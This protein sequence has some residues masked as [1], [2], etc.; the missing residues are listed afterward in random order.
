[1]THFH[2]AFFAKPR[3]LNWCRAVAVVALMSLF[4]AGKE[5][6]I[7][8]ANDTAA[9]R[10]AG[11]IVYSNDGLFT[12]D[13]DGSNQM[14]LTKDGD[15]PSF[16]VFA[17]KIAYMRFVAEPKN[18]IAICT[19]NADGTNQKQ[20]DF[21]YSSYEPA[22]SPHGGKIVFIAQKGYDQ[23][24]FLMDFNG[25]NRRQITFDTTGANLAPVW[26]Y[27][28]KKIAYVR[29]NGGSKWSLLTMNPNGT[30][31][32]VVTNRFGPYSAVAFSPNGKML[33]FISDHTKP[34]G[35]GESYHEIR[36]V[37]LVDGKHQLLLS[38]FG[39]FLGLC[40]SPD[41]TRIVFQHSYKDVSS[42]FTMRADGS[43]I[44][45]LIKGSGFRP[46][47]GNATATRQ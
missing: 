9:P 2:R 31:K 38:R 15:Q 40:F 34:D 22:I 25:D 11:K 13:A 32:K 7:T 37:N 44:K 10:A 17:D 30:E 21:E 4:V 20:I 46:S 8:V 33:A 26:S 43:E 45:Q 35:A 19:V 41:G 1:M 6:V 5:L 28:G 23:N 3:R 24:L 18:R 39:F 14:R 27:D 29:Y 12:M 16:S 42:L 47:W 36:T